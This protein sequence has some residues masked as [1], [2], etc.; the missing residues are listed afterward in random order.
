MY[1][2]YQVK[3]YWLVN[4]DILSVMVYRLGSDGFYKKPDYY[5]IDES[6]NSSVLGGADIP[7]MLFVRKK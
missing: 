2:R 7:L 6:V 5:C 1:E 3:E 4:G